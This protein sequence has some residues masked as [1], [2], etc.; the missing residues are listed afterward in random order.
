M[1]LFRIAAGRCSLDTEMY[2]CYSIF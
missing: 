2:W 1:P